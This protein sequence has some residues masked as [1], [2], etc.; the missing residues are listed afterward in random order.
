LVLLIVLLT[1]YDRDSSTIYKGQKV[2]LDV[3]MSL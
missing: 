2:I 1:E 3:M